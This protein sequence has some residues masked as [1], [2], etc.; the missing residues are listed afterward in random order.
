MRFPFCFFGQFLG[1]VSDGGS[2]T[3][4]LVIDVYTPFVLGK[5]SP[6][7]LQFDAGAEVLCR[8]FVTSALGD[9]PQVRGLSCS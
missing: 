1:I 5:R 3:F 8:V 4:R 2:Y 6:F 9:M 7:L